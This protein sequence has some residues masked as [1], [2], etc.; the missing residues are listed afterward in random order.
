MPVRTPR[1]QAEYLDT[2]IIPT[3]RLMTR[4]GPMSM[5]PRRIDFLNQNSSRGL[6]NNSNMT[7]TR[8]ALATADNYFSASRRVPGYS[9]YMNAKA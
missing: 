9:S 2:N 7:P 6:E 3:R 8:N 4:E 1:Y 5:S